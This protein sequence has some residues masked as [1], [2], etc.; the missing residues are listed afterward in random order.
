MP[1]NRALTSPMR[2]W[3]AVVGILAITETAAFPL[4]IDM[5]P[6]LRINTEYTDNVD[7][8]GEDR[9][10][11]FVT[12]ISPG[13]TTDIAGEHGT[14]SLSY[15]I[16]Y[17]IYS[18]S[19]DQNAFRQ[20]LALDG[21]TDLSKRTRLSFSDSLVQTEEPTAVGDPLENR[22]R[23]TLYRNTANLAMTHRFG[24]Y[25]SLQ[26]R[27]GHSLIDS[28]DE[29]TESSVAHTPSINY[30]HRFEPY[31][32]DL[33][34]GVAYTKG[35]FEGDTADVETWVITAGL[36]KMFT[37]RFR[38]FAN[39]RQTLTQYRGDGEDYRIYGLSTGFDA[40][41]SRTLNLLVEAGY[42]IQT[43]EAGGENSDL[44]ASIALGKTFKRATLGLNAS[45][46]YQQSYFDGENLGLSTYY[47][48]DGDWRYP[49]TRYL[50][51]GID[52]FWRLDEFKEITPE[53]TDETM[54]AGADLSWQIRE[55]LFLSINLRYQ[56]VDSDDPTETED[57][58]S[59][60]SNL[61]YE[62]TQWLRMSLGVYHREV[63]ARDN[64]DDYQ[65]N[66]VVFELRMTP[67]RPFRTIQ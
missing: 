60:G 64:D 37:R 25:D 55:P 13:F 16:G 12:V 2:L 38:G 35:Q 3:V 1:V 5:I 15:N 49:L 44:S 32:I 66:R 63:D 23:E 14:A 34:T 62:L 24:R 53:R 51:A 36:S 48:V 43:T 7:L 11:S 22:N 6:E 39:Y 4:V 45:T 46:G 47:Q 59:I 29:E 54:G 8:T 52:A 56:T 18:E 20:R 10:A 50:D 65:E 40:R 28:D 58:Y 57:S 21:E 9:T 27:Y 42:F 41:I 31:R 19:S 33:E 30:T 17:S 67:S 61:S 26:I